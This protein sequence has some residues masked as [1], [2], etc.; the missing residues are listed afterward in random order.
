MPPGGADAAVIDLLQLL[1]PVVG[2]D[3]YPPKSG[4]PEAPVVPVPRLVLVGLAGR[5]PL[6]AP[7][8]P[9]VQGVMH[10]E[11]VGPD[12]FWLPADSLRQAFPEGF[13]HF[14]DA[15]FHRPV[16]LRIVGR[17]VERDDPVLGEHAVD[18]GVVERAAVVALEEER[19]SVGAEEVGQMRGDRLTLA[20]DGHERREAV[21]R[22]EVLDRM[23]VK[24]L[25]LLIP[26]P[27]RRID[28]PRQVR[29]LPRHVLAHLPA[30]EVAPGAF[31]GGQF[32]DA[33]PGDD[34]LV[35]RLQ[36]AQAPAAPAAVPEGGYFLADLVEWQGSRFLRAR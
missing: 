34:G 13:L 27:F 5:V 28:R 26:A 15:F 33:A 31:L 9:A 35:P 2:V 29:L 11:E 21:P 6:Q 30:G 7:T 22:A 12:L 16:V 17:A 32:R 23:D 4:Q 20:V 24:P 19:G 25:A 10:R 14:P 36:G 8:G 3:A 18:G 1:D